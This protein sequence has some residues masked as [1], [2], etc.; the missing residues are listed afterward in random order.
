MVLDCDYC[1]SWV[2][3]T[4]AGITR[5]PPEDESGSAPLTEAVRKGE[6]KKEERELSIDIINIGTIM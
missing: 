1:D 6:R 4:C 2:H 3:W 5:E